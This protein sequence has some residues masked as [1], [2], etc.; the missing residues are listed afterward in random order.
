MLYHDKSAVESFEDG[1]ELA[2]ELI[3]GAK[4]DGTLAVLG[5]LIARSRRAPSNVANSPGDLF[6]ES[7]KKTMSKKIIR[8]NEIVRDSAGKVIGEI[9]FETVEAISEV[10]IS[11]RGKADSLHRLAES[12]AQRGKRLDVFYG[13]DTSPG[14]L[15]FLQ[16]SL[17]KKW[18]NRV[19]F[20]PHE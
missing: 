15:K 3:D 11:V 20:I 7:V 13:P 5:G 16:E 9:D 2:K 4:R 10:G 1:G 8:Q 12:A 17:A 14:R 18:G 6:E 19:R